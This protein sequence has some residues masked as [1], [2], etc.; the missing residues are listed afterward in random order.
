MW[1][2]TS[3]SARLR[4]PTRCTP[5]AGRPIDTSH[6][7]FFHGSHRKIE[8][9]EIL[10][11]SEQKAGKNYSFSSGRDVY[12][13]AGSTKRK[14]SQV[15]PAK[16]DLDRPPLTV[17]DAEQKAWM[18]ALPGRRSMGVWSPLPSLQ[19]G[20][21][22][23]RASVTEIEPSGLMQAD[24]R[25]SPE[26]SSRRL[27]GPQRIKRT[28]DIPPP[29]GFD[30]PKGIAGVQ[31][32]LPGLDWRLGTPTPQEKSGSYD[33]ENDPNWKV[34]RTHARDDWRADL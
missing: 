13:I 7:R 28:I 6:Q 30:F 20:E 29:S 5:R 8:G 33:I 26:H 12:A 21:G 16:Q 19:R 14:E 10:P 27:R 11:T 32:T 1:P 34:M 23:H 24:A 25:L 22:Y 4:F 9:E 17:A 2:P 15:L 31:G 18:W 3:T